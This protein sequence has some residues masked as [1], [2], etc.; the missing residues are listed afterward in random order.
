LKILIRPDRLRESSHNA[1]MIEMCTYHDKFFIELGVWIK[2]R[3]GLFMLLITTLGVY[4][5]F[6]NFVYFGD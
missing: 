1:C 6:C 5:L 2:L 3:L 4:D